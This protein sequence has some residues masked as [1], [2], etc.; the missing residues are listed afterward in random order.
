VALEHREVE[1]LW[2]ADP[3][4]MGGR[5]ARRGVAYRAYVPASIAALDPVVPASVVESILEAEAACRELDQRTAHAS[6][7]LE[8][9]ARQLL[10]AE[11]VAS[12]RIEGLVV[13]H[14]QLAKAAFA[15]AGGDFTAQ[16]VLQN[17]RGMEHALALAVE[18]AHLTRKVFQQI[19]RA[20]FL[21]TR[22]AR[23]AGLLRDRQNWIGGEATTPANAQ[24]VPPPHAQVGSLLADL[25]SFAERTD[26]SPVLQ[27][28]IA[29]AQFET[30]HPFFD[31][32]GRVGRALIHAV[33]RRRGL[34]QRFLPPVSLVL[35]ANAGAYVKGLTSYRYADESDWYALFADAVRDAARGSVAFASD[36]RALQERWREQAARPRGNSAASKL[37][38]VL[39]SNPIVN[40]GTAMQVTGASQPAV[41]RAL[42]RLER[43]GVIRQTTVGK[44]NRAFEAVG[45]FAL[46]D[47]LERRLGPAGR[48]PRATR[49]SRERR[50]GVVDLRGR[51]HWDGDLDESRRGRS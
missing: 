23:H 11:S 8:T 42:S 12:S 46:M 50:I 40:A 32:N 20:M 4:A 27:A 7:N 10:R 39:P 47:E 14:R 44:R 26:L 35:A 2:S 41:L 51:V 21:E 25:A 15:G 33:F 45:L 31:G 1:L 43:A 30:I 5:R 37:I 9:L 22:D 17:I 49:A 16:S 18:E 24:F 48:T 3:S 28:A 29:H 34:V 13:S 36:V 19:H 38:E 6:P